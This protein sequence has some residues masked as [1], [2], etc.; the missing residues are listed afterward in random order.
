MASEKGQGG[1]P[2]WGKSRAKQSR[3]PYTIELWDVD[4][5]GVER[6]LARAVNAALARAIYL[7]AREEHPERRITLSR[8]SRVISRSD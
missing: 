2:T 8:G 5:K 6:L 1:A 7:A 3:L 4:K